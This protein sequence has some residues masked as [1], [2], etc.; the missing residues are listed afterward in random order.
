MFSFQQVIQKINERTDPSAGWELID[1]QNQ[2]CIFV[3]QKNGSR[4][5]LVSYDDLSTRMYDMYK[6]PCV[7]YRQ[8]VW[9]Q[10]KLF[11]ESFRLILPWGEKTYELTILTKLHNEIQL[12]KM[13]SR[14]LDDRWSQLS[15]VPLTDLN[16]LAETYMTMVYELPEFRLFAVTGMLKQKQK[17]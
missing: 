17:G 6:L 4:N 16:D 12:F 13:I 11:K 15:A 1:E 3:N 7:I 8:R 14:P 9:Y 10:G 5:E 2:Q